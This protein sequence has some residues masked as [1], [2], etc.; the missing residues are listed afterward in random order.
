MEL[1]PEGAGRRLQVKQKRLSNSGTGQ[2]DEHGNDGDRGQQFVQHSSRFGAISTF[3]LVTPVRLPPGRFRLATSPILTGSVAI[4][5][6][7]GM[8]TVAALA[9]TAAGVPPPATITATWR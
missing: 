2:V 6:T 3:K 7:I 1:K 5:K 8:V 9:A 4:A